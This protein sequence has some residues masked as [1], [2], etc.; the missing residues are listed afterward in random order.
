MVAERAAGVQHQHTIATAAQ[1]LEQIGRRY[2]H[3]RSA[4]GYCRLGRAQRGM[5]RQV[6]RQANAARPR[7]RANLAGKL[8]ACLKLARPARV[9]RAIRRC[10]HIA[11]QPVAA[12]L[13]LG[14]VQQHCAQA[15]KPHA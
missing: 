9:V 11:G 7:Q 1:R 14:Q 3:P 2:Y 5:Q 15:Q 4:L 10:N 6:Q 13:P 12:D 8:S